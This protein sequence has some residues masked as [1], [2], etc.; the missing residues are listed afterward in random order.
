MSYDAVTFW[1]YLDALRSEIGPDSPW[2]FDED[3]DTLF[4]VS[5]VHL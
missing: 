1:R 2:I 4:R 5:K 3:A